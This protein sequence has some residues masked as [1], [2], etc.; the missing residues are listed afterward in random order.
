[1]PTFHLAIVVATIF[2]GLFPARAAPVDSSVQE[3]Y[4]MCQER[5]GAVDAWRC[6]E[7]VAGV[8]DAL[9]FSSG[10]PN[11]KLFAICGRPSYGAMVQAFK[12]WAVKHPEDWAKSRIYGVALALVQTWPC[13]SNN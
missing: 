9:D 6:T 4:R 7:Y 1:M 10:L 2:I 13:K 8:G 11:T 5:D 3:L 12:N